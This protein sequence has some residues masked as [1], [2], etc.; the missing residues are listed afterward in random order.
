MLGKVPQAKVLTTLIWENLGPDS[1]IGKNTL[2]SEARAG[3]FLS[4]D[5]FAVCIEEI[6]D[7]SEKL[8]GTLKGIATGKLPFIRLNSDHTE[9]FHKDMVAV[10]IY[11]YNNPPQI[12][13]EFNYRTRGIIIPV[14]EIPTPE[15]RHKFDAIKQKIPHGYIGNYIY[16]KTSTEFALEEIYN[17]QPSLPDGTG[18]R[19]NSIYRLLGVGKYSGELVV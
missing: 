5:S 1:A 15:Q 18:G 19:Q 2:E 16:Q 13:D 11:T 17:Q 7:M 9:R 12:M 4:A 8:L 14:G 6:E 10:P 3:Q